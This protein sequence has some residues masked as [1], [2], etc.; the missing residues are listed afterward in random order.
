MTTDEREG[1]GRGF[2][3][4]SAIPVLRMFDEDKAR[5]FYLDYL[6]FQVDWESRFFPT[7]PLYMQIHLGGAL[8]HLNGHAE[9]DAPITQVNLPVR[10]LEN[11]CQYLIA[12]GADY[13]R[14][15]VVAPRFRGRSTDMN[16]NDPF[17]NE[18]VFC[19]EWTEGDEP[20]GVPAPRWAVEW[21][22]RRAGWVAPPALDGSGN[23][24]GP[25]W[26]GEAAVDF[27]AHVA[28]PPGGGVRVALGG[29]PAWVRSPPDESGIVAFRLHARPPADEPPRPQDADPGVA[30]DP[31]GM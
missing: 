12:K 18:L 15:C 3:I 25:W 29:L 22:G 7:A 27:L 23:C 1:P 4:R 28:V 19:S 16:V 26:P 31:A 14:P 13:P 8:L 5:A 9:E 17:G 6:G 21:R 10:G 30:P 11:Y 24:S 2:E 20:D